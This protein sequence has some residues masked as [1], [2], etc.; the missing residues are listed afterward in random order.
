VPLTIPAFA[1]YQQPVVPLRGLWNAA[2]KEGD[3]FANCEIDWGMLGGSPAYSCVQFQFSG[4]SPVAFSQIAALYVDNSR[5]GSDVSFIFPDSAF[6]VTIPAHT[7]GLVP[8]LSNALM[9]Y[10]N[11]PGAVSG[12]VT[13][14]QACNSMPPPIPLAASSAQNHASVT[15]INLAVNASTVLIPAPTSGTLNTLALSLT[16]ATAGGVQV[17]LQDG[18]GAFL[19]VENFSAIAAQVSLNITVNLAGLA[20]RFKNGLNF[21]VAGS[22]TTGNC[23]ANVYYTTP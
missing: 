17:E 23:I 7:Q 2:P 15:G 19:W 12:D 3:K 8:V 9:F 13:I 20:L 10:A 21:I 11:A 4:N 18:A 14:F 1:Q 16:L 6:Q 5:C 22:T